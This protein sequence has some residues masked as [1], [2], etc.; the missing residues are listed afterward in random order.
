MRL[1]E[2]SRAQTML[3]VLATQIQE[4]S[5]FGLELPVEFIAVVPGSTDESTFQA[6]GKVEGLIKLQI[7][8]AP[9]LGYYELKNEGARRAAGEILVFLD[10]DTVPEQ[11]WLR[12]LL[13]PFSDSGAAASAGRAYID[14]SSFMGCAFAAMWFFP[15]R[16]KPSRQEIAKSI[17][18]NSLAIRRA[19]FLAHPF[20][21]VPGTSRGA[22]I[23]WWEEMLQAHPPV[24]QA[25]GALTT[26]P[27]PP[28]GSPLLH[29]CP[30]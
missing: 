23:A 16:S 22:C 8:S 27:P 6:L 13:A 15:I 1:A 5:R 24:M 2:Q 18:A 21:V 4:C 29:P 12:N 19:D 30:D 17:F 7:V 26:H 3:R 25:S 11:D 20:R 14:T 28:W 9:G 10:S